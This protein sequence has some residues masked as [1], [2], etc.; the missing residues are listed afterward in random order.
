MGSGHASTAGWTNWTEWK[1]SE[2]EQQS[3]QHRHRRITL[4]K[5]TQEH[6]SPVPTVPFMISATP[7]TKGLAAEYFQACAFDQ[8]GAEPYFE[9]QNHSC[10]EKL[11]KLVSI[12]D[13]IP[14]VEPASRTEKGML[15]DVPAPV[16]QT[17]TARDHA[18][19]NW[20]V[21]SPPRLECVLTAILRRSTMNL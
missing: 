18:L 6:K 16:P 9:C 11:P 15:V 13:R 21:T 14:E 10:G 12:H 1:K 7:V 2:I 20:K 19:E 17:T 4:G 3:R 5:A 8:R